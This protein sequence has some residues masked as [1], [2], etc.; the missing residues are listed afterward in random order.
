[1]YKA[2][3][4]FLTFIVLLI[5][6]DLTMAQDKEN[7]LE[8]DLKIE[9]DDGTYFLTRPASVCTDSEF[10]IYV[11]DKMQMQILV[12][13]ENGEYL[14][15]I[16][17][18]GRGPGEFLDFT[19]VY[20]EEDHLIVLD[21]LN[22]RVNKLSYEGELVETAVM[23]KEMLWPRE[24]IK[25]DEKYLVI[26]KLPL[27]GKY[28]DDLL[29]VY[30]GAFSAR[31]QSFAPFKSLKYTSAFADSRMQI[32]PGNSI[33]D[34][35]GRVIFVPGIY[36]G[37]IFEYV[38]N[39][40]M[41]WK[42]NRTIAG[43]KELSDDAVTSYSNN[44]NPKVP[45]STSYSRDGKVKGSVNYSTE[46]IY[47]LKDGTIVIIYSKLNLNGPSNSESELNYHWEVI[48]ETYSE[49]LVMQGKSTILKMAIRNPTTSIFMWK[50]TKD[51]FYFIE[52]NESDLK[53]SINR[54]TI[55]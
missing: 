10:N 17:R 22:K 55:K 38:L 35:R 16:G 18:R 45:H 19:A 32:Y 36:Y 27:K 2:Y 53:V 47:Q 29:H 40:E 9:S 21:N 33:L 11:S 26:Y 4:I 14:N 25:L 3:G 28:N 52:M 1:M 23:P 41:R 42:L 43:D 6:C 15:S 7:K 31:E 20:C 39:N 51:R 54:G 44:D 24:I 37:E 50:D 34:D 13:N 30:D 8:I 48:V 49:D 12:F 5:L 46:G